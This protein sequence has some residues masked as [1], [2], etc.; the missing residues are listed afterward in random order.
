M[1]SPAY[2]AGLRTGDTVLKIDGRKVLRMDEGREIVSGDPI[3]VLKEI[4]KG[5][6]QESQWTSNIVAWSAQ[7]ESGGKAARSEVR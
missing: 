4:R 3:D 6:I 2:E 1:G 5:K 7:C